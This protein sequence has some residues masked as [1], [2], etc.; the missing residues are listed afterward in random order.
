MGQLGVT[1][2]AATVD[3]AVYLDGARLPGTYTHAASATRAAELSDEGR[4]V[5]V[6]V[7]A[8]PPRQPW[9]VDGAALAVVPTTVAGI[10]GM[11][12][13]HM[14]ELHWMWGYGCELPGASALAQTTQ[15]SRLRWR[16]P[17][18]H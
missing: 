14:P 13:D 11:N 17:A 2:A 18:P 4:S 6:W 7:H 1:P 5:F 10:Y 3:C 12:F 9:Q 8:A 15:E 16:P